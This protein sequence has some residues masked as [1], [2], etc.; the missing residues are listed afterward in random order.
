MASRKSLVQVGI[1]VSAAIFLL[2]GLS[3]AAHA[4]ETESPP[5]E[6]VV[7]EENTLPGEQTVIEGN[8]LPGEQTV[9]WE[10][11][12][13]GEQTASEGDNLPVQISDRGIPS[14]GADGEIKSVPDIA[15][16]K[17]EEESGKAE[18]DSDTGEE[19]G[20]TEEDPKPAEEFD[21]TEEDSNSDI[22]QDKIITD[23]DTGDTAAEDLEQKIET[24]P[25]DTQEEKTEPAEKQ[26]I[27]ETI[28]KQEVTETVD[29]QKDAADN[30]GAK[31]AADPK[32]AAA[33]KKAPV[34]RAA[35]PRQLQITKRW[36]DTGN[37]GKRPASVVVEV[38][39][40]ADMSAPVETVT[41]TADEDWMKT[42]E[43]PANDD[44]GNEIEYTLREVTLS[45]SNYLVTYDAERGADNF[46]MKFVMS[47]DSV[48]GN[49]DR[50]SDRALRIYRV[51]SANNW[52]YYY[53][54]GIAEQP[55]EYGAVYGNLGGKTLTFSDANFRPAQG[56]L[57]P[58]LDAVGYSDLKNYIQIV[59]DEFPTVENFYDGDVYF[60]SYK[61]SLGSEYTYYFLYYG[62]S[63]FGG[64]LKVD[65][66]LF[67]SWQSVVTN[68]WNLQDVPYQKVW[69]D[70][71][72]E[73]YRPDTITLDLYSDHSRDKALATVT[74]P[75]DKAVNTMTGVFKDLPIYDADQKEIRYYIQEHDI[76][77][78]Y[79]PV[80][81]VIGGVG[82]N[83]DYNGLAVTFGE[84]SD[85]AYLLADLE[86]FM[87]LPHLSLGFQNSPSNERSYINNRTIVFPMYSQ[88]PSNPGFA[89]I[90][91]LKDFAKWEI[92]DITPVHVP[93]E[94]YAKTTRTTWANNKGYWNET[95]YD[96]F[97][98]TFDE[99]LNVT[100]A[101]IT[102]SSDKIFVYEY[103]W[104]GMKSPFDG[105]LMVTNKINMRDVEVTKR[106]ND[107]GHE[108]ERPD[109]VEIEFYRADDP[110][111]VAGTLTMTKD[112]FVAGGK[113]NEWVSALSLLDEDADGNKIIYIVK[114]KPVDGYLTGYETPDSAVNIYL[115]DDTQF[116]YSWQYVSGTI[117][118]YRHDEDND[119][120][121]YY[122]EKDTASNSTSPSEYSNISGDLRNQVFHLNDS[123]FYP[124]SGRPS[125]IDSRMQQ[126][127][128]KR[129]IEVAGDT[130]VDVDYFDLQDYYVWKYVPAIGSRYS[131]YMVYLG[132]SWEGGTF[133][134]DK[135]EFPLYRQVV[136]NTWNKQDVECEK[137]WDDA[138]YEQYRPETVTL[139]LYSDHSKDTVL[140]S[141]TLTVTDAMTLKGVFKDLPIYGD[142]MKKIQYYIQERDVPEYYRA[143][144]DVIGGVGY[145]KTYNAIAVTFGETGGIG[146]LM[147][148]GPNYMAL[149]QT[150]NGIRDGISN[151]TI[152]FPMY[153]PDDP[154]FTVVNW[155]ESFD[156]WEIKDIRPDVVSPAGYS[157]SYIVSSERDIAVEYTNSDK[158]DVF[159]ASYDDYLN[160]TSDDITKTSYKRFSYVYSWKGRLTP[161]PNGL[162]VRNTINA[163]D[164]PFVK[165]WDEGEKAA[166]RPDKVTFELYNVKDSEKP[167]KTAELTRDDLSDTDKN[168]W[169]GHFTKVPMYNEDGSPAEYYIMEKVPDGYTL[170]AYANDKTRENTGAMKVAFGE[171]MRIYGPGF[172]YYYDEDGNPF[173]R[174]L[175]SGM[176]GQTLVVPADEFYVAYMTMSTKQ[177]Y[178]GSFL[179]DYTIKGWFTLADISSTTDDA[180]AFTAI[181][182]N[183]LL[184]ML[185][186]TMG[187]SE[188]TEMYGASSWV[189][190]DS[191]RYGN[192]VHLHFTA[193]EQAEPFTGANYIRNKLTETPFEAVVIK[194]DD[195]QANLAGASLKITGR[196]SKGTEDIDPKEWLSS[197]EGAKTWLLLPGTYT[198]EE[199]SAPDGYLLAKPITFTI[200]DDGTVTVNGETVSEVVMIDEK[201]P[202]EPEPE[203]EKPEEPK[204]EEP[205]PEEPKPEEPKPEEPK[206]EEPKPEP[207]KPAA[208]ENPTPVF[209]AVYQGVP[210][211]DNSHMAAWFMS[212][213]AAA[214]LLA[215]LL[216]KKRAA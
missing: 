125:I 161:F 127:D 176:A 26:D 52:Q 170:E 20:K 215:V 65:E 116:W 180:S 173:Y 164:L 169:E 194:K 8:A 182:K 6:Q 50:Y 144:Y 178:G 70:V 129:P 140:D 45:D 209:A 175:Y 43:L 82:Y 159:Y 89:I 146:Y 22:D 196:W 120:W 187:E 119:T 62:S 80:Y 123:N 135:V 110:D 188:I 117:K 160:V 128:A 95:Y 186:N 73:Q 214:G 205:K 56:T 14:D 111:T 181:D 130:F 118:L 79:K 10:N 13:P 51:D 12:Q 204:P 137:E 157:S 74:I 202:E 7:I 97:Y 76:S 17:P 193:G 166:F 145:G 91:Y 29:N 41:L 212:V 156:K 171:D 34:L 18:T 100:A 174:N 46:D 179:P 172:L 49:S 207:E 103:A 4:A 201:K 33:P 61:P 68:I 112:D 106:W 96:V 107:E 42:I 126:T 66:I 15:A 195:A 190:A 9:I 133:H 87:Q 40:A 36:N 63:V 102:K 153:S 81:D 93:S 211:G 183:A 167:V 32:P 114:E 121:A 138:G 64:K 216:R 23:P 21:K 37:E 151:R 191:L 148:D 131:Y 48:L 28:E 113:G 197:A 94:A 25:A 27:T 24:E 141:I 165:V 60:W 199:I 149:A 213:L 1:A 5:G 189:P 163:S 150:A 58:G 152:L 31:D 142:D 200:A 86:A 132:D 35:A 39:N 168:L 16:P 71:G 88:N 2:C 3:F 101:D 177:V 109:S 59:G 55:Y 44:S 53:E 67:P 184:N 19:S 38:Y 122:W 134:T 11:T 208:P 98:G 54:E 84:T 90:N 115:S 30:S 136:I 77:E 104:Q 154:S 147:S 108:D 85:S 139:D 72:H 124:A 78:Y 210:T 83:K 75:V 47:A 69:D 192:I 206:P 155:A 158:Y 57:Y 198:L 92:L 99:F 105:A 162:K 185:R 143:V 203:P